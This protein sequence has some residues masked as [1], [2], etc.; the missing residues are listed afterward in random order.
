MNYCGLAPYLDYVIDDA[1]AKQGAYTPGTHLLIRDGSIL[2]TKD[3]PD[4]ILLFAWSFWNEI[5]EK[6]KKY[7][8]SGGKFINPLPEV[9]VI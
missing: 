3:R 2:Q 4:Y 5:Q 9:R 8:D 7:V 1:P 6:N